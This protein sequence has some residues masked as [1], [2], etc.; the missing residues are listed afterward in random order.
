MSAGAIKGITIK[1]GADASDLTKA[2]KESDSALK[3]TQAQLNDVNRA[4]KF[5]PDN[6]VLLN[7]K[8]RLLEDSIK[9]TSTSISKMKEALKKMD[10]EGVSKTSK[11]YTT[12]E[13]EIIKSESKLEH[14]NAEL[15]KVKA[16]A[17]SIGQLGTKF[18]AV[19]DKL[20]TMGNQLRAVSAAAAA[21][22][23]AIGGLA[24][25]SAQWADE[26]NTLSKVYSVSTKELQMYAGASE[27][28]DVDTKTLLASTQK[29]KKTMASAS[30]GSKASAAAYKALGVNVVDANGNLRDSNK[31]FAETLTA[32][33]KMTN[34]TER[35]ALAMKIFGKSAAQLN[36]LIEDG[37]KAYLQFTQAL[38]KHGI[39]YVDQKTLDRANQF[40]DAIDTTKAVFQQGLMVAGTKLAASLAP[41][42]EKLADKAMNLAGAI[43]N[44]SPNMLKLVAAVGSVV[45][46]LSPALLLFGGLSKAIGSSL[47]QVALLAQKVPM[48]TAGF[49]ALK[50]VMLANPIL[51]VVAALGALSAIV[52]KSGVDID[53]LSEKVSSAVQNFA[54]KAAEIIPKVVEGITNAMPDII[55]AAVEIILGLITGLVKALPTLVANAPKIVKAL[56][57]AI[58]A[59]IPALVDAGKQLIKGLW[60]GAGAMVSWVVEKFK[61]LGKKILKGI[62]NALGIHSPSREFAEVGRFSM[63]GL[64]NGITE[65][66]G[67]VDKAMDMVGSAMTGSYAISNAPLQTAPASIGSG[68]VV[69]NGN[70]SF[71]ND[72]QIDHFM[73]SAERMMRRRATV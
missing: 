7:Q 71:M 73:K 63:M 47:G 22:A 30:E 72:R 62:K 41:A 11:E 4:L 52:V 3:K 9:D 12:L 8:A 67:L 48:L 37:G 49:T 1:L 31:V 36:P 64:A 44:M 33:G 60:K 10:A 25:K 28:V 26:L 61:G 21:C 40:N 19:G 5:N 57:K 39:E 16:S 32:L 14:F 2:L 69:F 70:Y 17:S 20:T 59:A 45:G 68:S 34:E 27:L 65:N 13:R 35:D 6:V 53:G 38:E 15:L 58:I 55:N 50:A 23:V 56:A 18:S 46:V 43:S 54:Q 29:M 24:V 51:A 66:L 42:F